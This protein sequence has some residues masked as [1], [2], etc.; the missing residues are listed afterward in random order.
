MV[1]AIPRMISITLE[2]SSTPNVI[3]SMGRIASGGIIETNVVTGNNTAAMPLKIPIFIPI[4]R[5]ASAA[6]ETP[7]PSL[8]KLAS[9]SESKISSPVLESLSKQ[10]LEKEFAISER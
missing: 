8:C 4:R 1:G 10:S 7:I 3:K 6:I 2:S 5:P 9:V